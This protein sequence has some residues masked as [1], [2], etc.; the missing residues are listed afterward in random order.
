MPRS[1]FGFDADNAYYAALCEKVLAD[2]ELQRQTVTAEKAAERERRRSMGLPP[3]D[4]EKKRWWRRRSSA[5]AEGGQGVARKAGDGDDSVK[6]GVV[7]ERD[8]LDSKDVNGQGRE[9]KTFGE[10]A[11]NLVFNAGRRARMDDV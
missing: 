4:A 8:A 10:K 9:K 5:A 1:S 3:D 7:D 11:V 6:E 2:R